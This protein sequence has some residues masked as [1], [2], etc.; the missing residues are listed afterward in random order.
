MAKL[1]W[2]TLW[3]CT[4]PK[5]IYIFFIII[6][7]HNVFFFFLSSCHLSPLFT[8]MN[9]NTCRIADHSI[10][11]QYNKDQ[12]RQDA[13]QASLNKFILLVK[14]IKTRKEKRKG[15]KELQCHAHQIAEVIFFIS[16]ILVKG[17]EICICSCHKCYT[18]FNESL[19]TV[20]VC[21]IDRRWWT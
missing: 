16:S 1:S 6:F 8:P 19:Q 15:N 4:K 21:C 11:P 20:G 5:N 14:Y 3:S 7:I 13:L 2:S 17:K 9:V 18:S 12:P 10:L